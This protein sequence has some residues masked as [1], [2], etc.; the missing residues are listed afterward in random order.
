MRQ[1][2]TLSLD[3]E[4]IRKARVLAAERSTS[5][6]QKLGQ[7]LEA[8]VEDAAQYDQAKRSALA[9]LHTGFYLGGHPAPRDELHER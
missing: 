7:L 9:Q 2:L 1:N 4:L 6:N 3:K 5:V 8:M